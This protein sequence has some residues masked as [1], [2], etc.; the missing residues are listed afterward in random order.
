MIGSQEAIRIDSIKGQAD[1][2][3]APPDAAALLQ[4]V[5]WDPRGGWEICGGFD[6]FVP[7][8]Q[9]VSPFVGEGEIT[10]IK[11][12]S[13]HNGGPQFLVWEMGGK[14]VYFNGSTVSTTPWTTLKT[15]R[16]TT[17]QPWQR[18]Q[19]AASGDTLWI[20][21][22][23]DNPIRFTGRTT[24]PAGFFN[25]APQVSVEG[26]GE[27]FT[28][29]TAYY[30]LGLGTAAAN[31]N[32]AATPDYDKGAVDGGG[33]YGYLLT[34]V[35]DAGNE[36]PPSST[37]TSVKWKR[38]ASEVAQAKAGPPTVGAVDA[39]FSTRVSIP[40]ASAPNV[41]RRRLYRTQ[42]AAGLGLQDGARFYLCADIPGNAAMVWMDMLPDQYLGVELDRTQYGP[43]PRGAKYIAIFK[44]RMYAAGMPSD[45]DV[46]VYSRTDQL[47]NFPPANY[48]RV[49]DHDS[50]EI[51][52]LYASRNSLFVF[53][54]R[55]IHI[56]TVEQSG[57]LAIRVVT[58]DIGCAAPNSVREVPGLGVVFCADD[59]VWVIRGSIQD[60]D[61]PVGVEMIS[62]PLTDFF[63]WR[64]NRSALLNACAEVYHRD[65]EYW[66]SVPT[67]G[68]ARNQM[69][70]VYHY[71]RNAWSF[72][73]DMN[74]SCMA[75]SHD[76]RGFLFFGSNS[77]SSHPGVMVYSPGFSTKDGVAKSFIYK[78]P[79]LDLYSVYDHVG[80]R[81]VTIRA[82]SYG[83]PSVTFTA[84]K[85]RLP[86]TVNR[87]QSRVQ[88][89]ADYKDSSPTVTP[90][91]DT[92]KWSASATWGQA[93]PTVIRFDHIDTCKEFQYAISA[94]TRIQLVGT[95]VQITPKR[96]R[97]VKI[98][99]QIIG[100][101]SE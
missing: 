87:A 19:Y 86:A 32:G 88:T 4:D 45:P 21:N 100:T 46:L 96:N 14:L 83:T 33:E 62:Q 31:P 48:F 70:L 56:I 60:G 25:P 15:G 43:W 13:Q 92:A 41:M 55:G 38:A 1:Q 72:R 11:H 97:I 67:D 71:L 66:L 39:K 80:I 65:G 64:V 74:A 59:G 37:V 58:R 85:D 22:G 28:W 42:N 99:N 69:V 36:S 10:S 77:A 5:R 30:G 35:D 16:Y 51:T 47:G 50:G 57:Q 3:V 54:R 95:E 23:E 49:G 94:S 98:L 27:G 76:H 20:V 2:W 63:R 52:G 40:D 90:V 34:E 9:G 84:Y 89:D 101:G 61:T 75:E 82:L 79:P 73:P 8:N 44:G 81:G 93:V 6:Q 26:L 29:G 53:K 12:F 18:S 17:S 7:D 91:W 24:H 68:Q 78:S